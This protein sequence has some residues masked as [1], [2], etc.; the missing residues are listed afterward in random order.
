MA[1]MTAK[2]SRDGNLLFEGPQ[3]ISGGLFLQHRLLIEQDKF[4]RRLCRYRKV[5]GVEHW[6]NVCNS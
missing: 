2:I 5:G 4:L 1:K 6:A 3:S